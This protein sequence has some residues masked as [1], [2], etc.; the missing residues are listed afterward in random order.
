MRFASGTLEGAAFHRG[1]AYADFDRD[2]RGD[3]ALTRLNQPAQVLWNR[4]P[5]TGNWIETWGS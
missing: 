1:L 5:G 3:I 4:T 2:G